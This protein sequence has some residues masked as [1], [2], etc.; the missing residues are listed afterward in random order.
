MS[1]LNQVIVKQVLLFASYLMSVLLDLSNSFFYL[2]EDSEHYIPCTDH[3][4][5]HKEMSMLETKA[6]QKPQMKPSQTVATL[7]GNGPLQSITDYLHT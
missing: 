2:I 7:Q 3:I 5:I 1:G 6:A 4:K